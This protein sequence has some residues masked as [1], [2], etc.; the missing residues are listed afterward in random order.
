MI[1]LV[2]T[3]RGGQTFPRSP[4]DL[5]LLFDQLVDTLEILSKLKAKGKILA[6]G[7][8]SGQRKHTFI[9]EAE[10]NNEVTELVQRLPLWIEHKWEIIPLETWDHHLDFIN[11]YREELGLKYLIDRD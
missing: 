4:E 3:D 8:P 1:Y 2:I 6:G 5:E 9:I 10:S 11:Q 7:M